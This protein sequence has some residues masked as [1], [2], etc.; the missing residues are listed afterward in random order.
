VVDQGD[1]PA[2]S[3]FNS[4]H[5]LISV[6]R[7]DP[8]RA[9]SQME[10]DDRGRNTLGQAQTL[11]SV[12]LI[13]GP[14]HACLHRSSAPRSIPKGHLSCSCRKILLPPRQPRH[15]QL[16]VQHKRRPANPP[17]L[18]MAQHQQGNPR[19]CSTCCR[20]VKSHRSWL[21]KSFCT[22]RIDVVTSS[23]GPASVKVGA[24][25]SSTFLY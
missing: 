3:I 5:G 9:A 18:P 2:H 17:S 12:S 8:C 10:G 14:Q 13:H 21:G 15:L 1:A 22:W 4:T 20:I 6:S 16:A 23:T 25:A 24:A 19:C 7:L 11:P